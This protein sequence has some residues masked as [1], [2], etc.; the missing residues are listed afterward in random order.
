MNRKRKAITLLILPLV[1]L[2][3]VSCGEQ[4][5]PSPENQAKQTVTDFLDMCKQGQVQEAVDKFIQ[6]P[7][8]PQYSQY[9][10]YPPYSQQPEHV[11]YPEFPWKDALSKFFDNVLSY[12]IVDVSYYNNSKPVW[13][14]IDLTID[15]EGKPT[16]TQVT[17]LCSNDG[18]HI[19]ESAQKLTLSLPL[20]Q[21]FRNKGDASLDLWIAAMVCC[22]RVP[23][24]VVVRLRDGITEEDAYQIFF[25]HGFERQDVE[26]RYAPQTYGLHFSEED[27]DIKSVIKELML[28]DNVL[29]VSP[30]GI[31]HTC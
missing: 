7:E 12:N 21:A 11:E 30:N 26:K 24:E 5:Q 1:A 17:F 3:I 20:E 8:Q 27:R 16:Q 19:I 25:S 10:Q 28:D 22:E 15:C 13:V 2:L 6:P 9:P 4:A 14:G 23:N 31:A 29:N 18:R